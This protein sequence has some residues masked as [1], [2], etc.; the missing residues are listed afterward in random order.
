MSNHT[1]IRNTSLLRR[2][3]EL[4]EDQARLDAICE[5]LASRKLGVLGSVKQRLHSATLI[6][7]HM[8]EID[9]HLPPGPKQ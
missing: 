6:A 5:K 2:E 7:Q 4:A 1:K 8:I 3:E 9:K